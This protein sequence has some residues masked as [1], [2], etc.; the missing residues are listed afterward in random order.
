MHPLRSILVIFGRIRI[1][2]RFLSA[3]IWNQRVLGGHGDVGNIVA[4][5]LQLT[6][7]NQEYTSP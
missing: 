5:V 6:S 3:K 1:E 7:N 2:I 4:Y